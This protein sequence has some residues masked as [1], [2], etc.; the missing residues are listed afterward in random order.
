MAWALFELLPPGL[1]DNSGIEEYLAALFA[2]RGRGN[3][4]GRLAKPLHVIAVDLDSGEAVDFGPGLTPRVPVS[5]AVQASTALPGLYRPV[6]IGGRDW[7]AA[8]EEDRAHQTSPSE[9]GR[10]R[11]LREPDRAPGQPLGA[12]RSHLSSKG[13]TYV[14]DQVLRIAL[15]G[16]MQYGLERYKAEHPEVDILLIEPSR[17][18][19]GC[20]ATTSCATARAR[21]CR[22]RLPLHPAGVRRARGGVPAAAA[23]SRHRPAPPD[24]AAAHARGEP[25]PLQRGP[26]PFPAPSTSCR[27]RSGARRVKLPSSMTSAAAVSAPPPAP[28][29][30][31]PRATCRARGGLGPARPRA[32]RPGRRRRVLALVARR[33]AA[34]GRRGAPARL[35]APV[36]VRRDALGVPHLQASSLADLMRAQ[37]TSPPRT[38]CGRW[39]CCGG[40]RRASSRGLRNGGAGGDRD[41]RTLGLGDAARRA[42]P[43]VPPDLRV[44]NRRLRG[45]VNAWAVHARRV[46]SPRVPPAA[47]RPAPMEAADTLAV[48]KLL[49]LDLA[50][51]GRTRPCAPPRTTACPRTCRRC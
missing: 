45:G 42:L 30:P 12:F 19:L 26:A 6:R 47:L 14:L 11:H 48:G 33:A 51:D 1:L 29:P 3:D 46:P 13:V 31:I 32:A 9:R 38:A 2:S 5:K 37:A 4:F 20:S 36:T 10:S 27:P 43:Q 41:I 50:Q 44:L 35:T 39:T 28:A 8:G 40:A 49:A 21:S 25:L 18:D 7:D 22:A 34:G 24:G 15:H 23:A 16:R 17:D